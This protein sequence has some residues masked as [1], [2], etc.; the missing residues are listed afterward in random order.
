MEIIKLKN[1]TFSYENGK[2]VLSSINFTLCEGEKVGI[3]GPNGIGKTTLLQII[4]GLLKPQDGEIFIFGKKREKERDFHEVRRKI[5]FMF[6]DPD[7][8]LFCPTVAEDIAF[9]PL[10]LGWD[11]KKVERVVK[12][13]LSI[14]GLE[15]FEDHVTYKLSGGEKRLVALG[16]LLSMKPK[17]LL[18]DEP[19]GDLDRKNVDRLADIL[20]GLDTSYLIVSHDEYFLTKVVDKLFWFENNTFSPISLYP[21]EYGFFYQGF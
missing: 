12:E 16:S 7:D 3:M 18:L 10:N 17:V 21:R 4:V 9:G 1:L 14:L 20:K 11:R 8:Q 13:T 15:G 6:Q 2:E 19:T 5:G